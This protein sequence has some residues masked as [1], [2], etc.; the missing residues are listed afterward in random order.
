MKKDYR[1]LFIV[2]FLIFILPIAGV[3][4]SWKEITQHVIGFVLMI[5][6]LMYRARYLYKEEDW[7]SIEEDGVELAHVSKAEQGEVGEEVKIATD[8]TDTENHEESKK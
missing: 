8:V 5:L 4:E 6:A 3:P 1:F 7:K 2:G